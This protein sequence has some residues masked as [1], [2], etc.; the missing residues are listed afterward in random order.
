MYCDFGFGRTQTSG[1]GW[2]RGG[3][4]AMAEMMA[5]EVFWLATKVQE[6]RRMRATSLSSRKVGSEASSC[7]RQEE[8]L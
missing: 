8:P 7:L 5:G 6:K 2:S 3:G 4:K 1:V